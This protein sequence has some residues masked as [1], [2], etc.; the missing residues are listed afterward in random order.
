LKNIF[1][2]T[3]LISLVPEFFLVLHA[4]S[5]YELILAQDNKTNI[6]NS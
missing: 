1:I 2:L 4:I 6:H 5:F 3:T